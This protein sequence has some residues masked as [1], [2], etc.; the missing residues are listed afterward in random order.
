MNVYALAWTTG[1]SFLFFL[2]VYRPLEIAFPAKSDQRFVRPAWLT[3]LCFFL[4]HYFLWGGLVLWVLA[5]F[6][7]WLNAFIPLDF[8]HSVAT[9]PWWLQAAEVIVLSD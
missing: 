3:D 7:H 8:H 6:R 5:Q 9:Q 2:L 4:G 1:L